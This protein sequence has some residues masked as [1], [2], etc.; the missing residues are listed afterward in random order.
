MMKEINTI[1]TQVS[2]FR[3]NINPIYGE[4]VTHIRIEDEAAGPFIIL[5]QDGQEI[6]L[7]EDEIQIIADA[8]L[9]LLN[10][11]RVYFKDGIK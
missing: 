11:S 10:D 9:K 2:V 3:K 4:G 5:L 8:A 7:D 1:A 6:R